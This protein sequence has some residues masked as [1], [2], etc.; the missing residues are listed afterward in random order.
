MFYALN[1]T[2]LGETGC[3]SNLYYSQAAQ[4][5]SFLI[6]FPF[7]EHSQLGHLWYPTTHCA[8]LM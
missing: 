3:L 1:K 6:P 8:V 2:R 5:S 7:P 4:A